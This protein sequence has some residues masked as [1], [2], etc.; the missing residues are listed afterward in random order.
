[1]SEKSI[2]LG[3]VVGFVRGVT[4][5]K[6]QQQA[7]PSES[8]IPVLR[9]GNIQN[10][11]DTKRDLIFVPREIVSVP[12]L[13]GKGDIAICLSSG[14]PQIVGKT[15][16]LDHDWLGTVGGFCGIIRPK[17]VNPDFLAHWMRGSKFVDWR[18]SQA[19]GANIQNLRFSELGKL[20]VCFPSPEKQ[21]QIAARLNAQ[22]AEV[23][24]ARQSAEAQLRDANLLATRL[25]EKLL[26]QLE[27][28]PRLNLGELLLDIEAG[29]SF[30]TTDLPARPDQLGVLKV[31]AV[32]WDEFAP[33]EA[34]AIEGDYRPEEKHRVKK[35]DL[36]ISR[37]N[38][39]ELVGA[40]VRVS[41][42]YLCRLLSDKTLRLIVDETQINP[43]YLLTILKLPEARA[44]IEDNATGT[45]D[46]MRNISQKTIKKIPVP[47]IGLD[48]QK[49]FVKNA[50]SI[51]HQLKQINGGIRQ[52]KT[53]LELLPQKILAQAF[54]V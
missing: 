29:K 24:K 33:D 19:R 38:T 27:R 7:I 43:D 14:S 15:A 45:S 6:S 54:E 25:H 10:S 34:K 41:D 53:E 21:H 16:S 42:D 1:M 17:K 2:K 31:S 37:A 50:Q 28:A 44:H 48:D 26:N 4:F 46:S 5:D 39:I 20:E 32:S 12:Q 30:Q 22:L 3:E 40:V 51:S 49:E 35:G 36:I 8:N 47:L 52:Q 23:D 11:L 9:A 18:D 13:L